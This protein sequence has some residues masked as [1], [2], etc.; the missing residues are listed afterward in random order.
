MKDLKELPLYIVVLLV[1][2][3]LLSVY[4]IAMLIGAL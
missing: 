4:E 1:L 2:I 3:L